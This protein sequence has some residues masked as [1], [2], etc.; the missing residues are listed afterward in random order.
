MVEN[1]LSVYVCN[2]T[3]SVN[4]KVREE[5]HS[6]FEDPVPEEK[7]NICEYEDVSCLFAQKKARAFACEGKQSQKL[8]GKYVEYF[9]FVKEC[10]S[11]CRWWR[12]SNDS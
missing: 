1:N 7:K 8:V 2:Q 11:M 6:K 3:E 10:V 4:Y 9:E 5:G 12:M